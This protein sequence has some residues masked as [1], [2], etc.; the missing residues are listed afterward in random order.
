MALGLRYGLVGCATA[1]HLLISESPLTERSVKKQVGNLGTLID[2]HVETLKPEFRRRIVGHEW[3]VPAA[4]MEILEMYVPQYRWLFA[5][6]LSLSMIIDQFSEAH[7]HEIAMG[8]GFF[9]R[10]RSRREFQIAANDSYGFALGFFER[11]LAEIEEV[12]EIALLGE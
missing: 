12:P 2:C 5:L 6:D 4:A 11:R 7:R 3:R 10:W 1:H 9:G 8:C